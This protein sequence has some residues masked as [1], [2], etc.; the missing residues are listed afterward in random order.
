[1]LERHPGLPGLPP[2][3]HHQGGPQLASPPLRPGVLRRAA[4]P[5]T[6]PPGRR[7]GG[8]RRAD[9]PAVH[10]AVPHAGR[11]V[12]RPPGARRSEDRPR[13]GHHVAETTATGRRA[14]LYHG[15]EARSTAGTPGAGATAAVGPGTSRGTSPGTSHNTRTRAQ[16]LAR[17]VTLAMRRGTGAAGA[18]RAA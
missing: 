14:V 8:P 17:A 18:L 4:R 15:L 11:P 16:G 2:A 12:G 13:A 6:L 1:M 7:R 5:G 9:P 10:P 3:V